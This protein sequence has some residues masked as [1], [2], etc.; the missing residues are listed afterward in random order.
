VTSLPS[1]RAR[2]VASVALLVA[3]LA[4]AWSV[5]VLATGGFEA[6]IFGAT[7][8]SRDVLRPFIV[9]A[10][11]LV[12]FLVAGGFGRIA[13]TPVPIVA[14]LA[15]TAALVSCTCSTSRARW[16]NIPRP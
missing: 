14:A 16:P 4:F 12:A 13:V 6:R 3:V 10:A 15:S 11:A 1:I 7:I 9:G 2:R 5:L 8:R